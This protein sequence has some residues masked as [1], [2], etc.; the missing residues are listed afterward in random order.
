MLGD[1]ADAAADEAVLLEAGAAAH[2]VAAARA[3]KAAAQDALK[4]IAADHAA[5][6]RSLRG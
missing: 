3:R 4:A 1:V 5:E 6:M 2:D